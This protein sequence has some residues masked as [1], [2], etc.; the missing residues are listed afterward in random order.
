[1]V[2]AVDF[3]SVRNNY[4]IVVLSGTLGQDVSLSLDRA[5]IAGNL[6]DGVYSGASNSAI[7]VVRVGNSTVV[8]NGR[9][10]FSQTGTSTFTSMNNNMVAGNQTSETN[11]SIA[12]IPV[13]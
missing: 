4:G 11:G 5:L 7:V 3:V 10:G 12:L 2:S 13:H 8:D 1:V 6:L 9:Y